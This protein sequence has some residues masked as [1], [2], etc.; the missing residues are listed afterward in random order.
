MYEKN[1]QYKQKTA[2]FIR[3]ELFYFMKEKVTSNSC[4]SLYVFTV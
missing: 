1:F 4:T 2:L 3:E